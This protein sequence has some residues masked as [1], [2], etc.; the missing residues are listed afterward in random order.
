MPCHA[1]PASCNDYNATSTHP[2]IHPSSPSH[3]LRSQSTSHHTTPPGHNYPQCTI[4]SHNNR[5][6]VHIDLD[7]LMRQDAASIHIDLIA[8][9]HVIPQHASRSPAAPTAPRSLFHP[10]IVLLTH[11]WSLTLAVGQQHAALQADAVADDHVRPDGHIG[12]DA[13]SCLPDLRRRVDHYVAA[14]GRTAPLTATCQGFR[15]LLGQRGQVEAGPRQEV[16]GLP[17][18]HPEAL[19]V[20][21]MQ[22]R[23]SA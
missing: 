20:E 11:A 21:R 6:H 16:L 3:P 19:K 1:T 18:V 23:P 22:A 14:S 4:T 13:C 9:R 12:P 10:T 7:A 15:A 2:P 8:N 17:D 5:R